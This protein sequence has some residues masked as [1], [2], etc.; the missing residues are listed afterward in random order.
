MGYFIR[1][2]ET[3]SEVD[4][5]GDSLFRNAHEFYCDAL[6]PGPSLEALTT[7]FLSYLQ[8]GFD[9]YEAKPPSDIF[10][11]LVQDHA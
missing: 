11:L 9:E 8:K 5:S 4:E 7:K 1:R 2:H 10:Q 3:A 6:R